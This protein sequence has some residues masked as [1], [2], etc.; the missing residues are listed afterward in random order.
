M[1]FRFSLETG[2][3]SNDFDFSLARKRALL[4]W[5]CRPPLPPRRRETRRS[6][7]ITVMLSCAYVIAANVPISFPQLLQRP[8]LRVA[9]EEVGKDEVAETKTKEVKKGSYAGIHTSSFRDFLLKQKILLALQDAAFEHPSE[10]QQECLPQAI[11]GHDIICQAKSGMGKT[12]VFVLATLQQLEEGK[13]LSFLHCTC[14]CACTALAFLFSRCLC[15]CLL[16]F[17]FEGVFQRRPIVLVTNE[18]R[19][20]LF[21]H[22]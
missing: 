12:A 17:P 9:E 15:L 20:R 8:V 7:S 4:K 18:D 5:R 2:F 19:G 6:T 3:P 1:L 13:V 14:A 21:H 16:L 22:T 11:Y 10:V